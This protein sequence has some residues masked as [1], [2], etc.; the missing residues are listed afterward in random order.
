MLHLTYINL[1]LKLTYSTNQLSSIIED[2]VEEV[3]RNFDENELLIVLNSLWDR[4]YFDKIWTIWPLP[5]RGHAEV[6]WGSKFQNAS[7]ELS[8]IS[9]YS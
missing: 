9:N 8:C 6:K 4:K 1:V 5:S 3:R 2:V 7:N